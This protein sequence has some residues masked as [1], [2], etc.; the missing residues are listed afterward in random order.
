MKK[1]YAI[2]IKNISKVYRIGE[3]LPYYSL[4]DSIVKFFSNIKTIGQTN[5]KPFWA[6]RG[7]NLKIESGDIVGIIGKNGAG[8]ST[9]LKVLSRVTVPSEGEIKITGSTASLLEVGTG[10]HPELTGEENIFLSGTIIG[11]SRSEIKRKISKIVEFSGIGK[12]LHTQVKHYSSGMYV[13]L[14][15]AVGAF[16]ESDVLFIDEVLAV[17]DSEFQKKCLGTIEDM[18]KDNKRTVV[19]VSH[20]LALVRQ[21]CN[22]TA[23][24]DKGRVVYFGPTQKAISYYLQN[25]A[26]SKKLTSRKDRTGSGEI[27]V[28]DIYFTDNTGHKVLSWQLGEKISIHFKY[29][30]KDTSK[31]SK[32]MLGF[33]VR[34]DFGQAVLFHSNKL[35]GTTFEDFNKSGEF[36]CKLQNI[37]MAPG[38]YN[39]TYSLLAHNGLGGQYYDNIEAAISFDIEPG[40]FFGTGELP[41]PEHY[42]LAIDGSWEHKKS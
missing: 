1:N 7:V 11:M 12:F 39:M 21:I 18:S 23:V 17:G 14:A 3:K 27:Y 35:K 9:L 5:K 13:R 31:I 41:F 40:D 25:D 26:V 42:S 19:F 16:L 36:I 28:T 32:L 24:M 15:F 29:K 22:K 37:N 2:E 34:N 10:F 33:I 6:L 30:T 4:R 8:K 20:N 38:R